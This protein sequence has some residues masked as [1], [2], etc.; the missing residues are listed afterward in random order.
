[1]RID[2]LLAGA[3]IALSRAAI[4][5]LEDAKPQA[6]ARAPIFDEKADGRVQISEAVARAKR[7]NRRVL[8]EWGANW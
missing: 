6:T 5:S 7:E 1:M 3:L 8:V 4:A 2:W